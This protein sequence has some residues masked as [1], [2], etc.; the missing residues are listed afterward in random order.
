VAVEQVRQRQ[1][2]AAC[3]RTHP[4]IPGRAPLLEFVAEPDREAVAVQ[5]L[6]FRSFDPPAHGGL[7]EKDV[8]R[9]ASFASGRSQ[10]IVAEP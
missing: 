5:L 1:K 3:I 9:I 4:G 7:L 10:F 8:L 6:V 2:A